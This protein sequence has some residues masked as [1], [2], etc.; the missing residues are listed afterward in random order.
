MMVTAYIEKRDPELFLNR[1]L[2]W[3]NSPDT[4][5]YFRELTQNNS[6][7]KM[8]AQATRYTAGQFLTQHNDEHAEE[9]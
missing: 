9:G 7:V 8:N 4:L 3:L 5:K 1:Y 6:I 2:E